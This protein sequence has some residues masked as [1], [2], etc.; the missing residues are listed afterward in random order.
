MGEEEW[1]H[2]QNQWDIRT[3]L[4]YISIQTLVKLGNVQGICEVW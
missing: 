3:G 4:L 2:I 1:E